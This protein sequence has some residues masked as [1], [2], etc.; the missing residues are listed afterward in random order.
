MITYPIK[1]T[2]DLMYICRCHLFP[3]STQEFNHL[4]DPDNV[5]NLF[6]YALTDAEKSVLRN[7]LKF[8]PTWEKLDT[9]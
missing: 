1:P 8:C 2:S 5:V 7:G 6:D 3:D 9:T 4:S